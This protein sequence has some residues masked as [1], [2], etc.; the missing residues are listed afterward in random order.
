MDGRILHVVLPVIIKG[1]NQEVR[2]ILI[3]LVGEWM[4]MD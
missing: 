4:N 3:I 2:I 1:K